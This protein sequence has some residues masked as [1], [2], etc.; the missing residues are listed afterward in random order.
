MR[1]VNVRD[2]RMQLAQLLDAVAAGEHVVI[3]RRGTPTARLVALDRA[4]TPFPDR[5]ALRDSLPPMRTSAVETV[6][7]LR[8]ERG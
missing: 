1:E 2:T 3:V 6:R 5:S 7:S 8:D 4:M